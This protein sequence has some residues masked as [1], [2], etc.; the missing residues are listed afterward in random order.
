MKNL[1]I[2][3]LALLLVAAIIPGFLFYGKYLDMKETLRVSNKKLSG[4]DE[5][6]ALLGEDRSKL[7]ARI[8]Q[9]A[10]RLKELERIQSSGPAL[11]RLLPK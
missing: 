1:T 5:K 11:N 3:V 6:L 10:E 4:L 2:I 7:N 9:N 8:S